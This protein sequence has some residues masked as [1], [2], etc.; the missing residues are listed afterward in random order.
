MLLGLTKSSRALGV[1]PVVRSWPKPCC[2]R[3]WQ[4]LQ[5]IYLHPSSPLSDPGLKP[6]IQTIPLWR[7]VCRQL[8]VDKGKIDWA[9]IF[10][11]IQTELDSN[12]PHRKQWREYTRTCLSLSRFK[13]PSEK[14][15]LKKMRYKC[16]KYWTSVYNWCA[17]II[18]IPWL[19]IM[20]KT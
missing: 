12:L 5:C 8:W 19:W 18:Y 6:F 15:F 20:N 7:W 4:G 3:K 9:E 1:D 10:N 13:S 17:S 14:S 2:V 16:Q 11:E